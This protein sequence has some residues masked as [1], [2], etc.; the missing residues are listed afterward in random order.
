MIHRNNFIFRTFCITFWAVTCS[1]FILEE[2]LTPL[3]GFRSMLLLLFDAAILVLGLMTLRDRRQIILV[4]TFFLLAFTSTIL[5][6][7]IGWLNLFNGSRQFIGMLFAPSIL[8]FL[9]NCRDKDRYRAS[10]DR[11]MYIFLWIQAFCVTWQ[12]IKY[13]ANDHGGGSMG[14]GCSGIISTLI[15]LISYYFTTRDFDP[16]DFKKSLW[17]NRKYI[18]LIYPVALNETKVSMI[19]LLVYAVLLF[20]FQGRSMVKLICS[21]PV[22]CILGLG[23]QFAYDAA[24]GGKGYDMGDSAEMGEYLFGKDIEDE[25]GNIQNLI[26]NDMMGGEI[27]GEIAIQDLPRFIKISM[28]P[29]AV[30]TSRGGMVFGAGLGHFKGGTIVSKTEFYNQY[31]WLITGTVN[32]YMFLFM[33]LGVLGF[34]WFGFYL[35]ILLDFRKKSIA[36]ATQ[37]KLFLL[38]VALISIFYNESFSIL[39]FCLVFTFLGVSSTL[40]DAHTEKAGLPD[41]T[42]QDKESESLQ[43]R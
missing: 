32:M 22:I 4:A 31:E 19:F 8:I 28:T 16:S 18:L 20:H 10:L 38:V 5:L 15:I 23:F 40:S 21:L 34:V 43:P 1:P 9:L 42:A 36:Y 41:P 17:R 11:Q 24:L 35:V 39:G 2:W 26:D 3:A 12:F 27:E 7:D 30:N 29:V 6:N 25:I 14:N 33:Q 13:G 37:L